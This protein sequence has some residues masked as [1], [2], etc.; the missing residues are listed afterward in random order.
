MSEHPGDPSYDTEL[1][2]IAVFVAIAHTSGISGAAQ[3][4]GISKSTVSNRLRHLEEHLGVQLLQRT[5]RTIGLTPA[6]KDYLARCEDIL[7]AAEAAGRT[8]A[9]AV[10]AG[11]ARRPAAV[12]LV[13][14][15]LAPVLGPAL[16]AA[17]LVDL[18]EPHPDVTVAPQI[19][20]RPA[21]L[22]ADGVDV[23]VAMGQREPG[24]GIRCL[25]PFARVVVRAPEG[26]GIQAPGPLSVVLPLVRAGLGSATVPRFLVASD[27]AAATLLAE[28]DRPPLHMHL[29][30]EPA[31]LTS[32]GAALVHHLVMCSRDVQWADEEAAGA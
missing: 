4:L 15:G 7:E 20:D 30:Y 3:R 14:I 24:R 17:A 8:A 9:A 1:R 18:A 32:A 6:G 2:G 10:V 11:S 31:R 27:L 16:L 12:G 22:E 29:R 23:V 28:A 5:T 19:F 26:R 25:G 21:H 13:R